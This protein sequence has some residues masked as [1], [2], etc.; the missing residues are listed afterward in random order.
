MGNVKTALG[1]DIEAVYDYYFAAKRIFNIYP[2]IEA[3]TILDAKLKDAR[4]DEGEL[5][6]DIIAEIMMII[7]SQTNPDLIDKLTFKIKDLI[8]HLIDGDES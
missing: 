3:A 4:T 2:T 5:R 7:I 6:E 8:N 1:H